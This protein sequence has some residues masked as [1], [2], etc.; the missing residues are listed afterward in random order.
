MG[1][2]RHFRK[3]DR[4]A[5]GA[6]GLVEDGFSMDRFVG[7]W[8]V[9]ACP[10]VES[11]ESME[12]LGSGRFGGLALAMFF[13]SGQSLERYGF[14]IGIELFGLFYSSVRTIPLEKAHRQ[15]RSALGVDHGHRNTN[16][17]SV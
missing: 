2:Y 10:L 6:I 13:R 17:F 16:G 8:E 1:I 5:V 15:K 12:G 4:F 11:A 9:F 7:N 14:V 3:I